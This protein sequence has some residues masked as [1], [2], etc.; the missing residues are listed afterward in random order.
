MNSNDDTSISGSVAEDRNELIIPHPPHPHPLLVEP[1][2]CLG[3]CRG[4]NDINPKQF[5][6]EMYCSNLNLMY[7]HEKMVQKSLIS[8]DFQKNCKENCVTDLNPASI[9]ALIFSIFY[10]KGE[11]HDTLLYIYL[12]ADNWGWDQLPLPPV[13]GF[14]TR[15]NK[16]QQQKGQKSVRKLANNGLTSTDS[17]FI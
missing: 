17:V 4:K 10:L 8:T 1:Y 16:E 6:M 9:S 12:E 5:A 3:I 7:T 11:N 14:S 15:D 13:A 2:V